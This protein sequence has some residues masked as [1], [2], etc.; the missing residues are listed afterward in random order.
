MTNDD[1]YFDAPLYTVYFPSC[2]FL[3]ACALYIKR[4]RNR[5]EN[6][7]TKRRRYFGV[8]E[9]KLHI[10]QR[11]RKSV[12]GMWRL[13]MTTALT[14]F[15][16][17]LFSAMWKYGALKGNPVVFQLRNI[18]YL[19]YLTSN[20]ILYVLVSCDLRKEYRKLFCCGYFRV[21]PSPHGFRNE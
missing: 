21:E 14:V 17:S 9:E 19:F 7:I 15:F 10:L 13:N 2:F 11:L 6:V 1:L 20:P 3:L 16:V 12:V 18:A 5:H 8:E 4:I